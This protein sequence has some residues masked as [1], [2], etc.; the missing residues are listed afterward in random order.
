[1]E[2]VLEASTS[3]HFQTLLLDLINC[4]LEGSIPEQIGLLSNLTQ[5]SL[6]G[7]QL[8]GNL[9]VSLTR[10]ERLDLSYNSFSGELPVSLANLTH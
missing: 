10:L 8:T 9:P 4:G 1:M 3:L 6:W 5:L 7:N 2:L